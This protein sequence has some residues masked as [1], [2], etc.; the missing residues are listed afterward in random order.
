MPPRRVK[1]VLEVIIRLP[2]DPINPVR[3]K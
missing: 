3:N 2:I 1:Y